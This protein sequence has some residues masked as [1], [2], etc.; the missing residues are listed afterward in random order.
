[1]AGYLPWKKPLQMIFGQ[2]LKQAILWNSKGEELAAYAHSKEEGL[3][4]AYE[5]HGLK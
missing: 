4:K 2:S 1:M 5:G 3:G